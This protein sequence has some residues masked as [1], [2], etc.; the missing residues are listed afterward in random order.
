[1]T[2]PS[3]NTD[4]LL[5]NAARKLLPLTGCSGLNI[6]QVAEQAGVNLGMFHYHFKSKS[7]FTQRVLSEVYEEFFK[8][9]VMSAETEGPPEKRL[10]DAL[11]VMG[12]FTRE[13]RSLMVALLRDV[14]NNDAEVIRFL[15]KNLGRHFSHLLGLVK[16]CRKEGDYQG[17]PDPVV[18][19][20]LLAMVG[21]PHLMIEVLSRSK[22]IHPFGLKRAVLH[23]ALLSDG[24]LQKRIDLALNLLSPKKPVEGQKGK[25]RV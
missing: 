8:V 14:L 24:A 25:Q 21:V 20:M 4:Q 6:R 2:R 19:L 23:V 15:K 5:I 10:R 18:L 13:R 3:K 22:V 12:R 1:M 16:E 11:V 9:L 17:L 7:E